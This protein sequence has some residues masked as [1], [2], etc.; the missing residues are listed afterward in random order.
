[1]RSFVKRMTEAFRKGD[2]VLLLL[3]VVATA[4]GCLIIASA[5]TYTDYGSLRYVGIQLIAALAGIFCYLLISSIDTDFFP[6]HRRGLVLFNIF[7]LALLIP[8]GV[9]RNGNRSWLDFPFLPFNIQPA[10]IC[11]ITFILILA[12]VMASHQNNLSSPISVGHMV[13]HLLLLFVVNYLISRDMGVSL[14]FAFIFVGM[15]LSGGV[16]MFWFISAAGAAVLAFP[17]LW[18]VVLQ[19]HQK[20]RRFI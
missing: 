17:I 12:S 13:G 18:N 2:L 11:K 16:S 19:E 3:C 20:E 5:T 6:E 14:I 15:T 9:T 4:F 7:L 8:F 1:M 10:E